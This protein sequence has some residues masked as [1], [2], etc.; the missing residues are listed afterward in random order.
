MTLL[1][2]LLIVVFVGICVWAVVQRLLRQLM[3]LG[4]SYVATAVSGLFYRPAATFMTAIGGRT[5]WLTQAVMFWVLFLGVTIA[6]EVLLRRQFPD[7]RLVKLRFLD[8]VLALVPGILCGLIVVSLLFT[9]IGHAAS[10]PGG[11]PARAALRPVM[12]A[13]LQFYLFFHRLW[14]PVTPPLLANALP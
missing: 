11:A 7:V 13:F 8:Y 10:G 9:S 12:G 1:D 2:V 4:V 3:S 5:P 14:F 6:L